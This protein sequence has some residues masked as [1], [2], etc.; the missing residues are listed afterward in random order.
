MANDTELLLELAEHVRQRFYGKYRGTVTDVD[1]STLRIK[2]NVPAVL[3]DVASGW[4][5]PCVPY[6]G[7]DVG[8]FFVPD[9]GAG[10][11]IEFEGGD[12]SYPIWVGCYWR[13]GELPSDAGPKVRGLVTAAPH[14]LLF[15]DGEE[16]V[17]FADANENEVTLDSTGIT[18]ARGSQQVV[19]GD[20]SVSI[21]SGA[22]EVM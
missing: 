14:K 16:S 11:W 1:E 10:V 19:V 13:D 20:A 17:T 8:F 3:G 15:D 7:P 6:A 9:V 21:N 22:L 2:A 12:V 5:M 18:Q 4:C